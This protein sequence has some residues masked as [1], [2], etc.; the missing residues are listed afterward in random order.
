MNHRFVRKCVRSRSRKFA[1]LSGGQRYQY[2]CFSVVFSACA[3]VEDIKSFFSQYLS[4]PVPPSGLSTTP[5]IWAHNPVKLP[6][7]P[8]LRWE[9]TDECR[10]IF[11]GSPDSYLMLP[12]IKSGD[13][14]KPHL[15][16]ETGS[17]N[18]KEMVIKS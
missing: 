8:V 3:A 6:E 4:V 5:G 14:K 16:F 10:G 2:P 11:T 15:P 17:D 13:D 1:K 18:T 12:G 9:V 7:L